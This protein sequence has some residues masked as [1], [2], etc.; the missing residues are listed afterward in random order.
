M[1]LLPVKK[2]I[3]NITRPLNELI[4][5]AF[6]KTDTRR[7]F[8]NDC[9]WNATSR[10]YDATNNS[11]RRYTIPIDGYYTI[12]AYCGWRGSYGKIVGKFQKGEVL[13]MNFNYNNSE[14]KIGRASCRERV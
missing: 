3:N 9:V 11:I 14:S 8:Y 13:T 2:V 5:N 7:Y 10:G 12:R 6:A 4:S 1:K